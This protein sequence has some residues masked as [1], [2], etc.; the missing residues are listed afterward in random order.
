MRL[1]VAWYEVVKVYSRS[2]AAGLEACATQATSTEVGAQIFVAPPAANLNPGPQARAGIGQ[3]L[4]GRRSG[5]EDGYYRVC[6]SPR[7]RGSTLPS[8]GVPRSTDGATASAFNMT[9]MATR[10]RTSTPSIPPVAVVPVASSVQWFNVTITSTATRPADGSAI[11]RPRV[12]AM[13]RDGKGVNRLAITTTHCQPYG[14]SRRSQTN[15]CA[16]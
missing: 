12:D 11:A 5:H 7:R 1:I 13:P 8:R 4:V 2:P 15:A 9:T 14:C 3:A 6:R 16:A 10:H